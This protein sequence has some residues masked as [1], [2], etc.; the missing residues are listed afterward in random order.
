MGPASSH[1]SRVSVES[2][3]GD[4]S[5]ILGRVAHG[6][7]F[8]ADAAG[9]RA[10]RGRSPTDKHVARLVQKTALAAGIR[11]DLPEGDRRLAFAGHSLRAG[12]ATAA[13]V[14]EGLIQRRLGHASAKMTRGY[15][16]RHE[17]FNANLTKAA[18]L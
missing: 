17:K 16:R 11:G 4:G 7:K 9:Q 3:S 14:E 6:P 10:G 18:G 8:P 1:R 13:E 5:P 15:Q 12:L 2:I